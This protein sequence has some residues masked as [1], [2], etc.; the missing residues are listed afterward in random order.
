MSKIIFSCFLLSACLVILA[1]CWDRIEINDQSLWLAAGFDVGQDEDFELSGQIAIPSNLSTQ[2]GG[3]GDKGYFIISESGKNLGDAIQQIQTKLP[4]KGFYA[5]QRV[6]FLGEEFAK[7][8]IYDGFDNITRGTEVSIRTDVFVVKGDT[9]KSVLNI[10]NPLEKPPGIAALKEH[11]QLGGRGTTIFLDFLTAANSDG[12]RPTLPLIE[13]TQA[14][15]GEKSK[16]ESLLRIAGLA[17][18][19]KEL[20]LV[21]MLDEE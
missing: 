6:I 7:K 2:N 16:K 10:E 12:I 15:D 4:R 19:N 8:G 21:G 5:H 9:A 1:G 17:I 20:K 18:F 3:G 14:Q 13:I 11:E